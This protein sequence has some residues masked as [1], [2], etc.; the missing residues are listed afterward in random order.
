LGVLRQQ[1]DP[2]LER[3]VSVEINKDYNELSPEQLQEQIKAKK[4][5]H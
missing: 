5:N 1:L 2:Q 3:V 4:K